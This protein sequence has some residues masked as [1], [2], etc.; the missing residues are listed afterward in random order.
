MSSLRQALLLGALAASACGAVRYP[1]GDG[2]PGEQ[3][4][5]RPGGE[6]TTGKYPVDLLFMVDNSNSMEQEQLALAAAFPRLLEGLRV[7]GDLP[8]LHIGVVSSDLGTAPYTLPSCGAGDGGRLLNAPRS[9][10]CP[11]PK[12]R[13]ISYSAGVTNV[14]EGPSDPVERVKASFSCIALVGVA[15][16]GFEQ[17]L[18]SV[19]RALDPKLDLNPGFLRPEA[20]LVIFFISDED[21]CSASDPALFDPNSGTLGPLDSYRCTRHGVEC[22]EDLGSAGV[23]TGCKAGGAK[24][25]SA[26]SYA[27][28]FASL[29]PAGKVILAALAGPTAF[30]KVSTSGSTL[31]L[32][33][34][35]QGKNGTAVP[36]IRLED[37]I[38]RVG[39][40][41]F[42][43]AGIDASEAPV[44]LNACNLDFEPAL[45]FLA[46]KIAATF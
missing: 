3:A 34:S 18:E 28:F 43:N 6:R 7:K 38:T 36:A 23:K 1:V 4:G 40:G 15:G 19:R 11:T 26:A 20:L 12:E 46:K 9:Q 33:P 39:N 25:H 30:V 45:R 16:C 14:S 29:K 8:D 31:T 5:E 17:P 13:W 24:L 10:G 2:A 32:E 21:D 42:F 22:A 37:V 41:S 35:C 27:S 44:S